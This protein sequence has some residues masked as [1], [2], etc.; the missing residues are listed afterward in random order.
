VRA[1]AW[2][3]VGVE[4]ERAAEAAERMWPRAQALGE[5]PSAYEPRRGERITIR[6][7][8][9]VLRQV[10]L[11]PF[12]GCYPD[13]RVPGAYAPGFILA[14]ASR[15]RPHLYLPDM[16]RSTSSAVWGRLPVRLISVPSWST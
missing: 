3:A 13:R 6:R 12:Q 9:F 7:A 5:E 15:L 10:S 16:A 2:A 8:D 11:S 14:A 1:E 4:S